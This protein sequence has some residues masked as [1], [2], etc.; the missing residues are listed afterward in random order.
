MRK[1]ANL[2]LVAFAFA[3]S[4]T[5]F[6]QNAEPFGSDPFGGDPFGGGQNRAKPAQKKDQ[7]TRAPAITTR[8]NRTGGA[9]VVAG[10]ASDATRR[11]RATL[12]DETT[13]T[14]VD[15][16]LHDA[17][18]TLS[19][20]HNIP[21]VID[22]RALEEIGL[23]HDVP[24]SLSLRNVSLRSFLRLMLRELDLTYMVK[25]EV[26]QIT[27]IEAA[28][29]NLFV[30]MYRFPKELTEK[31]DKVISALTA[32]IVPGAWE[33]LGGPCTVSSIENVLVVS[34]T[35]DIHDQVEDFLQK[36]EQA[37]DTRQAKQ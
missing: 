3:F 14:F 24:V 28:E 37:L 19:E 17:V 23:S 30:E 8:A 22:R 13:Q 21:I 9:A 5:C 11:I 35:S 12:D 29:Q 26:M 10:K 36:L 4:A 7:D 1:L 6:A 33:S 15:I 27:T 25:D 31:S 2:L 18:R 32:A 34:A 20:S 16:P